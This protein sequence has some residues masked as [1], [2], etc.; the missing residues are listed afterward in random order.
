MRVTLKVIDGAASKPEVVLDLPALIGRSR[1]CQL[2]ISH[3][4]VS[5]QHCRLFESDGALML[6]DLGSLNGT[7]VAG[8]PVR[9]AVIQPGGEFTV[10]PLTFR[11]EYEEPGETAGQDAAAHSADIEPPPAGFP[12]AA[13]GAFAGNPAAER[14]ATPPPPPRPSHPSAWADGP[15]ADSRWHFPI[16]GLHSPVDPRFSAGG[17]PAPEPAAPEPSDESD[18]KTL[19]ERDTPPPGVDSPREPAR[20]FHAIE[21]TFRQPAPPSVEEI[22][23][24]GDERLG[25]GD[26]A[27]GAEA[28]GAEAVGDEAVGAEA[29]GDEAVGDEAVGDMPPSGEDQA[30][31]GRQGD[32]EQAASPSPAPAARTLKPG[33]PPPR[34]SKSPPPAAPSAHAPTPVA[35]PL[36]VDTGEGQARAVEEDDPNLRE[37]F[38]GL[39]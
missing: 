14:E 30:V 8:E 19:A 15:M 18:E 38:K 26:E 21:P 11:A 5:R 25:D 35:P 16:E 34:G 24:L 36:E 7:T 31:V 4:M 37:F 27:A 3:P 28:A 39:A 1:R 10:G 32:S 6:A 20:L 23:S 33:A 9:E 29:V 13:P 2:T 17:E 22:W 12:G